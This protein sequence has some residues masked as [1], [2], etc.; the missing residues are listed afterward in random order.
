[1]TEE[2]DARHGTLAARID[3]LEMMVA[4][5]AEAIED[6][7]KTITSQWSLV[8]KLKRSMDVLADRVQEAESRAGLANPVEQPPPHY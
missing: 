2:A 1:M 4:H 8:D 7:N 3:T 5:Q 6:L